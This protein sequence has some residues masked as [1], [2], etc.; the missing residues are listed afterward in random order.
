MAKNGKEMSKKSKVIHRVR[1]GREHVYTIENAYEG[2]PSDS[3]KAQRVIFGK[4]NALVNAIMCDPKQVQEWQTRMEEENVH[5][6]TVRQYV[7][8]VISRQL[9]NKPAFRRKRAKLP[10]TLPRGVRMQAKRFS[11]LTA[12]EVYEILKA[13]FNVFVCEQHIHYLDEDNIDYLATHY[14]LR[15][16]GIVIA[17][18]RLFADEEK[19]VMRVGRM[20]TLER[21]KGYGKYLMVKMA[22]AARAQGAHTL[23]LHA[24]KQAV[25]FYKHL[26]FKVVGEPF[27]EAEIPHVTMELAL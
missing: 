2:P 16:N 20:L 14:S 26:D 15:Q 5:S 3:Q 22:N 8:S 19:G 23:R 11:D 17:Y 24:Q 12:G 7:Y 4:T 18:A 13:R 21:N 10:I 25:P 27:I 6:G 9:S 1:N